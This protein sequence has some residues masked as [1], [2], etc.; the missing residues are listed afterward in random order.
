MKTIPEIIKIASRK[1]RKNITNSEKLLWEKLRAKRFKWLKFQKQ[2]CLYVF[3]ENSWLDR[4]II[5]DFYCSEYKLIIELDW[6]IHN[7]KDIY[8]L[9]KVKEEILKNNWYKIL[10]F[11]NSEILDDIEKVLEK[12]KSFIN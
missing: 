12:I 10:R 4:Y 8:D 9:D 7:L 1:L 5:P 2:F 6:S 3:T 11:R